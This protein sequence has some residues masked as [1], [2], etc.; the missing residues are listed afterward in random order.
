MTIVGIEKTAKRGR[1][2]LVFDPTYSDPTGIRR[3]IGRKHRHD[4]PDKKLNI[5]RRGPQYLGRYHE[6]EILT[7]VSL[8]TS[9]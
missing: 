3:Y 6:F 5:Y 9:T 1:S 8:P 7:Y 2:L 4:D